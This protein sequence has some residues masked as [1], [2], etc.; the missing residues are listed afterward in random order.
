MKASIKRV[1][2]EPSQK[3]ILLKGNVDVIL[4]YY[5]P[6]H[7]TKRRHFGIICMKIFVHESGVSMKGYQN[8]AELAKNIM[9]LQA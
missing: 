5:K 8:K 3:E 4:T 6:I 9:N 2:A 7:L 1:N